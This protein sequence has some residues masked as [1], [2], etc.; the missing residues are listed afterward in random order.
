V[1]ARYVYCLV[2]VDTDTDADADTDTAGAGGG[3]SAPGRTEATLDA[4]GLDDVPTRLIRAEGGVGAVVHDCESLYDTDDEAQLRLWLLAHQRV[5]DAATATFGTP[6]PVRFDTVIQGDDGAVRT[7]LADVADEAR[8]ALD[9][10]AGAREYRVTAHWTP[11]GDGDGDADAPPSQDDSGPDA[12]GFEARARQRDDRLAELAA[13]R[14]AAD[15]GRAFLVSKQYDRRLR[16]LERERL[17]ELAAD[18][19]EHVTPVAREVRDADAE[20]GGADLAAA[21]G[22][23]EGELIARL[24]VLADEA[25]EDELGARLDEFVEANDVTVRFTGPWAPYSFAPELS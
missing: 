10:L 8:P 7:W 4:V 6:L 13:V 17:A 18:L 19:R 22:D 12:G 20:A 9:R 1:T 16:E 15:T 11:D 23:D 14:V 3:G 5:V 24:T 21:D 25:D 2:R